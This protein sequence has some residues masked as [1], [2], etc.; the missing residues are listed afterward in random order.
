MNII[1]FEDQQYAKLLPLTFTK[2]VSDIRIGI[3]SLKEKWLLSYPDAT[4]SHKVLRPYLSTKYPLALSN[5]N[6]FVNSRLIASPGCVKA[7][8]QLQTGEGLKDA[9]GTILAL[10]SKADINIQNNEVSGFNCSV[11]DSTLLE[12]PEQIFELNAVQL[13]NDF[14]QITKGRKSK[15]ISSTNSCINAENIFLEDGA[16]VEC[17][18]LNASNG[19]I[20]IAS[21]AE[22]MEGCL[23]RGGLA[24]CKGATLKMGAKIYGS[25]SIGPHSKVGGEITNSVIQGYSNKGHDG[26]L[27]NSVIGEWCNIGADSNTSNLKNNYAEVKLWDYDN[28]KFRLTGTQFC[29]LIMG[30]HSKCGINTMF[31][32]GTVVG[33]CSNLFGSGFPRNY[34]PS[35]AWGGASGYSTYR[36][37]KVLEVAEVVMGRRNIE[38]TAMDKEIIEAVF[39]LTAENRFWER[40][41][42]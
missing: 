24:L 5:D 3:L 17:A 34:V 10:R 38:L 2:P 30:D 29:G 21:G 40:K 37:N 19:P 15:E 32:T 20:Y 27:G 28:K 14:D 23:V 11:I 25:T 13:Q 22:I 41:K 6:V 12:Y 18:T 16:K 36:T 42:I 26:F 39:D 1:L 7:I 33:V 4:I 9:N 8:G 31:N 35:F